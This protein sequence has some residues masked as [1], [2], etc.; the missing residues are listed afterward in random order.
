M[1]EGPFTTLK[2]A[3]ARVEELDGLPEAPLQ[4]FDDTYIITKLPSGD[5]DK[6]YT[7]SGENPDEWVEVTE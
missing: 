3:I 2:L 7:P 6:K 5:W 4:E 1:I